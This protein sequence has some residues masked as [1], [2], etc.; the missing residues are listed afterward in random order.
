[1]FSSSRVAVEGRDYLTQSDANEVGHILVLYNH[2]YY[3]VDVRDSVGQWLSVAAIEKQLQQV[4][5]CSSL[6]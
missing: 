2:Q 4:V 1:M 3:R 5:P 6:C